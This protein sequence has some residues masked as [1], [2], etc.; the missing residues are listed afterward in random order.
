LFLFLSLMSHVRS[1][2]PI[3]W[4]NFAGVIVGFLI[5]RYCMSERNAGNRS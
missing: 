5:T 1:P 3:Y 2:W 4:V